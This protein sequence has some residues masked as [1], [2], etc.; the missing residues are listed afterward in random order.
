V[1]TMVSY[2]GS[3]FVLKFAFEGDYVTRQSHRQSYPPSH[4]PMATHPRLPRLN[5]PTTCPIKTRA[6]SAQSVKHRCAAGDST[7]RRMGAG[8]RPCIRLQHLKFNR[9]PI[10]VCA[11]STKKC[12]YLSWMT[13]SRT[14]LV[15]IRAFKG[16]AYMASATTNPLSCYTRPSPRTF[17]LCIA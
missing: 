15:A 5:W 12:L 6:I 11:A 10:Y 9:L 2:S 14:R 4:I 8:R 3:R 17:Q 1:Q 16:T 7:N 13:I